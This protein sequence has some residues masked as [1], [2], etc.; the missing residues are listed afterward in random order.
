[1][2]RKPKD[3][4]QLTMLPEVEGI[5]PNDLF[6]SELRPLCDAD[7]NDAAT[8]TNLRDL[9]RSQKVAHRHVCAACAYEAGYQ[10]GRAAGYREAV[11]AFQ[12]TVDKKVRIPKR[13]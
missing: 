11:R 8:Y 3:P 4:Q 7:H 5:H 2:A 12:T 10:R 13:K 1:M 9:P 6:P